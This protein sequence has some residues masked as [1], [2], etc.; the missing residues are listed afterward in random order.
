MVMNGSP[1]SLHF[2]F[3]H[4]SISLCEASHHRRSAMEE[5]NHPLEKYS[6]SIRLTGMIHSLMD[7]ALHL[8]IPISRQNLRKIE[9][10]SSWRRLEQRGK[11][12]RKT[13]FEFH[14]IRILRSIRSIKLSIK[15]LLVPIRASQM[16]LLLSKGIWILL[17]R[18][19]SSRLFIHVSVNSIS[20]SPRVLVFSGSFLWKYLKN[21]EFHRHYLILLDHLHLSKFTSKN[22]HFLEFLVFEIFS[23][24]KFLWTD[25]E[26]SHFSLYFHLCSLIFS[27]MI[28]DSIGRLV[29][30]VCRIGAV[31]LVIKWQN[32]DAKTSP[33]A[34]LTASLKK[35][36]TPAYSFA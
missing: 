20:V 17:R 25:F 31:S 10:V 30:S 1:L 21:Y 35:S 18:K 7:F 36:V 6:P 27:G 4:E 5:M 11:C 19:P 16:G 24:M 8:G 9:I 12:M 15:V 29:L 13:G 34:R 26:N 33:L 2:W 3:S 14:F 32:I 28:Q 23:F 22:P